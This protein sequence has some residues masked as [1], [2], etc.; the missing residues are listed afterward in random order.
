MRYAAKVII[1]GADAAG[2]RRKLRQR[3]WH[4]QGGARRRLPEHTRGSFPLSLV[5]CRASARTA[6]VDVCGTKYALSSPHLQAMHP[7]PPALHHALSLKRLAFRRWP[8]S[9]VRRAFRRHPGTR[10]RRRQDHRGSAACIGREE[11]DTQ[12][13][14]GKEKS[15]DEDHV[16]TACVWANL[17][18]YVVQRAR[19]GSPELACER[20]TVPERQREGFCSLRRCVHK[21]SGAW[22]T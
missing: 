5:R 6:H 15:C 10:A 18:V 4:R 17:L 1:A 22:C 14:R 21:S 11:V 19:I 12:P 8:A 20:G 9:A 16:T 3:Q 7:G 13:M 2:Q